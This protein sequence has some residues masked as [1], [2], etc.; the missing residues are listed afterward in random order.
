MVSPI[1]GT[2]DMT[3]DQLLQD[4]VNDRVALAQ[5]RIDAAVAA[6]QSGSEW[7][8]YLKLQSSL[9]RY[10]AN[11]V[12]LIAIQHAAAF[13]QGMVDTPWP[14][15]VA[16]F[17][18]WKTL[19]R[20]VTKGQHGYQILAPNRRA[21][22]V[23][24]DSAG[25]SRTLGVDEAPSAGE[26]LETRRVLK[27][28]RFEHVFALL[29]RDRAALCGGLRL[30]PWV[31]SPPG[32]QRGEIGQLGIR[33]GVA[34]FLAIVAVPSPP[35]LVG[36]VT[37]APVGQWLVG[38]YAELFDGVDAGGADGAQV[39]PAVA[40]VE[41][42][43]EPLVV[44]EPSQ[45]GSPTVQ[46]VLGL[47]V[48][49]GSTYT[50]A[51]G[52]VELVQVSAVLA[53]EGVI[54]GGG[55]LGEGVAAGGG[56]DPAG[57]WPQVLA[58]SAD[59]VYA[60]RQPAA[61]H[62]RMLSDGGGLE[63]GGGVMAELFGSTKGAAD[64]FDFQLPGGDLPGRLADLAG[65]VQGAGVAGEHPPESGCGALLGLGVPAAK[66]DQPARA[67]LAGGQGADVG[68]HVAQRAS[69][70][71]RGPFLRG[72]SCRPLLAV[73]VAVQ[74][75][76]RRPVVLDQLGRV[77]LGVDHHRVDGGV[78]EQGLD[79]VH[80]GV[81]VEVL[82]GEH[83]AAVVWAQLQWC[84]VGVLGAGV[85]GQAPQP[86]A[87]GVGVDCGGVPHGLEQVR[88]AGQWSFLVLVAAVAGWDVIGGVEVA[89]V[90]D[91]LGDDPAELVADWDAS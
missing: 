3:R 53:G 86:A 78:P 60:D 72:G 12:W 69:G 77:Q 70:G 67:V 24:T 29:S 84:A 82:G 55:Q 32:A 33:S 6:I 8:N 59:E 35:V 41:L 57:S 38:E 34:V 22:R 63:S 23:A 19:G 85:Q 25:H 45:G 5:A 39:G 50:G 10:S 13:E 87:D 79:D 9:H 42:V 15:Y 68:A 37:P 62:G 36:D 7:R 1:S 44:L 56:Q 66:A 58:S 40:E 73:D 11:N 61:A 2:H 27:G 47:V 81:G 17:N 31:W 26:S 80:R 64:P 52:E 30:P 88:G 76:H 91:D 43:D 65:L 20:S 74:A 46:E 90:G 71:E 21:A 51:V 4:D 83:P 75:A 49:V 48:P 54:D 89:H 16:G 18:T 28:F 14:T